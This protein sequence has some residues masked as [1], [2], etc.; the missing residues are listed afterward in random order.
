M[1]TVITG[2]YSND[3]PADLAPDD[4]GSVSAGANV[5]GVGLCLRL[6]DV[7]DSKTNL[8]NSLPLN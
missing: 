7:S 3:S 2:T 6:V 1:D 8:M 5:S 4:S